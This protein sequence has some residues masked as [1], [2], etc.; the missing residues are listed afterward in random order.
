MKAGAP[1]LDKTSKVV[2][3]ALKV[4]PEDLLSSF[5]RATVA[6]LPQILSL[7]AQVLGAGITWDDEAYLLWRYRFGRDGLRGGDCLVVMLNGQ[8]HGLIG[9]EDVTLRWGDTSVSGIRVMDILIQPELSSI[10]LGVWIS[11]VLQARHP[12]VLAVG[13]NANSKGLVTRLFDVL[14]NRRVWV[15]PIRIDHF[16]SKRLPHAALVW[17]GARVGN[18]LIWGVRAWGVGTGRQ[19]IVVEQVKTLPEQLDTLLRNA[20]GPDLIDVVR[21]RER[22]AWRLATPRSQFAIWVAHRQGELLGLTI[23]R[24]DDHGDG[25]RVWTLMDVVLDRRCTLAAGKAL[26]WAVLGEARTQR[27]DQVA[28]PSYRH[29]LDALLRRA[30]FVQRPNTL[31]IMAW[32]CQNAALKAHGETGADWSFNEIHDDSA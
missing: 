19:G 30:G 9:T 3:R 16:L 6:D 5:R 12:L 25:Q 14:P 18:A 11:Q 22:L 26:L 20:A 32:S 28:L 21:S 4:T 10:G 1:T 15:C 17:S 8:L 29:D 23:T 24:R 27:I 13:A 7:R 2:A 31:K